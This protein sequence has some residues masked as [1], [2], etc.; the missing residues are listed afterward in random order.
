MVLSA[1]VFFVSVC[2][3]AS[4]H[5]RFRTCVSE[6]S[7]EL[8]D[9]Q[10][11]Q[12][13]KKMFD[14][15]KMGISEKGIMGSYPPINDRS[16]R[17]A[18]EFG[19]TIWNLRIF[20]VKS[21]EDAQVHA[22]QHY[23]IKPEIDP[24]TKQQKTDKKGNFI[25][26]GRK[27]SMD[28]GL[29]VIGNPKEAV[30]NEASAAE[31]YRHFLNVGA[32]YFPN[33]EDTSV[34]YFIPPETL[35]ELLDADHDGATWNTEEEGFGPMILGGDSW[36]FPKKRGIGFLDKAELAKYA[37]TAYALF[38]KNEGTV[39]ER[40]QYE[41]L[42]RELVSRLF[43]D[44][45]YYDESGQKHVLPAQLKLTFNEDI[46]ATLDALRDQV[47]TNNSKSRYYDPRLPEGK[48]STYLAMRGRFF[49]GSVITNG[50]RRIENNELLA[51]ALASRTK[52]MISPDSVHYQV[53][54][55]FNIVKYDNSP[56]KSM[57]KGRIAEVTVTGVDLAKIAAY[58][59]MERAL[60]VGITSVDGQRVSGMT[61]GIG[62]LYLNDDGFV[63][64]MQDRMKTHTTIPTHQWQPESRKNKGQ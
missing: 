49:D 20:Y 45:E 9:Q 62:F 34:K 24:I 22:S 32:W 25:F 8:S 29:Y 26:K 17:I 58:A 7:P 3:E 64:W 52:D 46:D 50:I 56:A 14:D 13:F 31:S 39:F 55:K 63:Q 5:Q 15:R 1:L 53:S 12:I 38:D 57:R 61:A 18:E 2:A 41:T 43:L 23:K 47:R 42:N 40:K 36:S 16:A 44:T 59:L 11:R 51:G 19:F 35:K 21:F 27:D 37:G 6:M 33:P 48:S 28:N 60:S 54:M 30:V 4:A 10:L